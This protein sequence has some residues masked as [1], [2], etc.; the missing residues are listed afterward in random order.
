VKNTL[1]LSETTANRRSSQN[2]NIKP[3][4]AFSTLFLLASLSLATAPG[5]S[6]GI[7]DFAQNTGKVSRIYPQYRAGGPPLRSGTFFSLNGTT[8]ALTTKTSYYFLNADRMDVPDPARGTVYATMSALLQEAA[9]S[10][11]KISVR[12]ATGPSGACSGAKTAIADVEYLV[13]DYP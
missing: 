9:Q 10:Q 1:D 8:D 5:A 3:R 11:R 12:T 2:M 7:C 13:I 6:A 4:F